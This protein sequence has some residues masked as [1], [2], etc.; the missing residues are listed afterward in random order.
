MKTIITIAFAL[1]TVGCTSV[2][3]NMDYTN[4]DKNKA[5]ITGQSTYKFYPVKGA[6]Y[7]GDVARD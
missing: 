7:Y 4:V 5:D 3:T 1:F 6:P 2:H